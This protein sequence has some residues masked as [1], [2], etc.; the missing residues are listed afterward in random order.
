MTLTMIV[1]GIVLAMIV[2]V[3]SIGYLIDESEES[4][5]HGDRTPSERHH[6]V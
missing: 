4:L 2:I 3:G 5:E 6:Q 1:A